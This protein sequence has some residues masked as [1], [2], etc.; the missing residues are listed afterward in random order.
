MC[1]LIYNIK[2]S[3]GEAP[4]LKI[5]VMWSTRLLPS[6]LGSLWIGVV[7]LDRVLSMGQIE[8]N[9][10]STDVKLWLLWSDYLEVP[11]V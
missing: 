10:V 2:P 4:A 11:V 6:L 9:C 3:D 7:T 1:V 5:R 8:L